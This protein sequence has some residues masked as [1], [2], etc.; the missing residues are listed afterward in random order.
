[1]TGWG[2]FQYF[3]KK[4]DFSLE[5]AVSMWLRINYFPLLLC[6]VVRTKLDDFYIVPL[7]TTGF[8]IT[9]ATCY[10]A[11]QLEPLIKAASHRNLAAIGICL[12]VHVLFYETPAVNLLKV[13][14]QEIYFRFQA[15]KYSCWVGILTGFL[16]T[17]LK[18]AM[19]FY[20][21]PD[22][23]SLHQR[24]ATAAQIVGGASLIILWY[25]CCYAART[26]QVLQWNPY[27]ISLSQ[28]ESSSS[29]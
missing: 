9:M 25:A 20:N 15:D 19:Q 2:N 21:T 13:F 1:M 17:Y 7:H 26:N 14:S 24:L 27:R 23:P 6:L 12:L 11:K 8:F 3:D 16:W 28:T 5:R 29:F 4:Q 10:V 22:P 18:K